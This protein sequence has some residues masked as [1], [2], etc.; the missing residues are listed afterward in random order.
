[1]F[2]YKAV[3]KSKNKKANIVLFM[4]DI[5]KNNSSVDNSCSVGFL[6][7]VVPC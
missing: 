5:L 3:K 4:R 1:M 6:F 7:S 2:W